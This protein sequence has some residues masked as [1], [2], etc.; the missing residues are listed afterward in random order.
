MTYEDMRAV[1]SAINE[2]IRRVLAEYGLAL[3]N[4]ELIGA[5]AQEVLM[6][7]DRAN[8]QITRK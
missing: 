6:S 1:G 8:Y 2:A 7:I 3:D 4:A 5:L